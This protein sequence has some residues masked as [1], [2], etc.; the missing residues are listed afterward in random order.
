MNETR[1]CQNCKTDF[2]IE[3]DDFTFYEKIKVPPPTFCF[4]CRSQRRMMFR[5]ERTLYRRVNNTPGH[6]GEQMI[7][8]YRPESQITAYDDRSW[9]SDSW[10]PFTY[11]HEYDFSK[12]FFE[13]F[14][15][16]YRKV[17]LIGL[18]VT[19]NLNCTF[20]NVSE[21]DKACHML[22]G[23]EHNEDTIYGNRVVQNRQSGDLY[24]AFQN[25]LSY[26]LVNCTKCYRTLFSIN[27][28]ECSDSYFL[29]NCKN[30]TDC[31]GCI[32]LR[33][34]SRCIFNTQYSKEEYEIKKKELALNTRAG[35]EK[36]QKEFKKFCNTQFYKYANN[37]KAEGSTGDNLIGVT[38]SNN[39]F[40]FQESE[41]LKNVFWGM[42]VK[43][44]YD[45]GPGI[46]ESEGPLY[47]VA[48]IMHDSSVF[49]SHV[50]YESFDV[51]Y[52]I[53]CHSSS[54]LFGCYG[55]RSK[56]YCIL[57]RQYTK[58]EY[59]ML[60][61]KII[62]H[63][64]TIP[65]VDKK[66]RKFM[67]GDFF[68]YDVSLFAYNETIAQEYYPLTSE[69]AEYYGF[70]WYERA[71]RNYQITV[72]K[73]GIPETISD[74][75]DSILNEVIECASGG[76]SIKQC[77]TAFRLIPQE[78][79]LYKKLDIPIPKFCYNC[80]HYN[81]LQQR[82][83]MK[84]WHRKCMCTKEKHD[85]EGMCQNEFKTSYAPDRTET[86]YCESCYQKEVI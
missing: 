67:Y 73:D 16:L 69:E 12:T 58:E 64:N 35:I 52:S 62:E 79:E 55:L 82:N 3:Q 85:H 70:N 42:R 72:S 18:S 43:N 84:L 31:I 50:I 10:D 9:W 48:D 81:R 14:A 86:I 47:E 46:G 77:T 54:H 33:S 21:G 83:P 5:N 39:T 75:S 38:R 34:A 26:E 15:E 56:E 8:I 27:S 22:S 30:C 40:D 24:V 19:N 60:V 29:S 6:E 71:E 78:I 49:F 2:V 80:R 65:Y 68:P 1:N 51:R 61:P 25:E 13:Q 17:P 53:N 20:C 45:A 66:G 37:I 57:N 36:F 7:S 23:S 63:M 59:E 76:D 41:D 32:N 4:D 44:S 74:V 11:G 28:Q